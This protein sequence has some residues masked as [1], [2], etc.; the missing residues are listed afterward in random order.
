MAD[1]ERSSV[2]TTS[3]AS[4]SPTSTPI[5]RWPVILGRR[6][7]T[8]RRCV[9]ISWTLGGGSKEQNSRHRRERGI[10][11]TIVKLCLLLLLGVGGAAFVVPLPNS[12]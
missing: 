9:R 5:S 10:L 3:A 8:A 11:L 2:T 1:A 12:S 7:R 6:K 4:A